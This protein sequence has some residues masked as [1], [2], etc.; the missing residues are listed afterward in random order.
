M[1]KTF[2]CLCLLFSFILKQRHVTTIQH[3]INLT[4]KFE[5]GPFDWGQT[6]VEVVFDFLCGVI[7]LKRYKIEQ[8]TT[9]GKSYGLS[10][11]A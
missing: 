8:V 9:N 10:V 5:G 11:C 6:R 2:H 4:A 3:G 7:S 1:T